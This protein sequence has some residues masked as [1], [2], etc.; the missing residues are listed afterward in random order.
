[1]CF[2]V[3]GGTGVGKRL[4]ANWM[5]RHSENG[6]IK[7]YR[8]IKDIREVYRFEGIYDDALRRARPS[9]LIIAFSLIHLYPYILIPLYP[10]TLIPLYLFYVKVQGAQG[11]YF[12]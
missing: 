8:Y 12:I 6:W 9:P 10:Y 3:V 11:F 1:M 4:V 5:I 2:C 7:V